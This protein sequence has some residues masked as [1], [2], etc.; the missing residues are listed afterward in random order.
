MIKKILLLF[1]CLFLILTTSCEDYYAFE[2]NK[3]NKKANLL[4]EYNNNLN[5]EVLC[6]KT[7]HI[8]FAPCFYAF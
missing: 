8:I 6:L 3:L 7:H 5:E 4:I 2:A 1:L